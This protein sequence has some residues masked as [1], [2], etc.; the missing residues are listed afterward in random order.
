MPHG[1]DCPRILLVDDSPDEREMYAEWFRQE[2]Y[3]T[4]QAERATDAYRLASELGPDV[5]IVDVALSGTEDGLHLTRLLKESAATRA[6]PVVVL[7]GHVF[8]SDRRAA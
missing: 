6:M 1:T 5:A 7:T 3:L 8:P 2:G 4:L